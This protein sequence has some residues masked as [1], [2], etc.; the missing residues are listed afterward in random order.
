MVRYSAKIGTAHIGSSWIARL[1]DILKTYG[2]DTVLARINQSTTFSTDVAF[3][4]E[5]ITT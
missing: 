4:A 3:R 5:K 2:T 1:V